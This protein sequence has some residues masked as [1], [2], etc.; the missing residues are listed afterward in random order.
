M[1]TPCSMQ[2]AGIP[3]VLTNNHNNKHQTHKQINRVSIIIDKWLECLYHHT[4]LCLFFSFKYKGLEIGDVV[5]G[6]LRSN[7]SVARWQKG[8]KL[9]LRIFNGNQICLLSKFVF[10]TRAPIKRS[11][12]SIFLNICKQICW[13]FL[14]L[15][16]NGYAF[17]KWKS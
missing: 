6:C 5:R 10:S 3:V 15:I 14:N 13:T 11:L 16:S 8:M 2:Y 1:I 12:D 4:P 17:E 7:A 9:C